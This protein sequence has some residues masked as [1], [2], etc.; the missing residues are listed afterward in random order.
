M[1]K[2]RVISDPASLEK[3][4]RESKREGDQD[5]AS[6]ATVSIAIAETAAP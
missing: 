5:A 1:K 4:L 2:G 6:L 3:W